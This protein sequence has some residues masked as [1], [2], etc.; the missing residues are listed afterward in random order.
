MH[1]C[2]APLRI[3]IIIPCTADV[4]D[5]C[6]SDMCMLL[7]PAQ[8]ACVHGVCVPASWHAQCL[9]HGRLCSST[10]RASACRHHSQETFATWVWRHAR[11]SG[12]AVHHSRGEGDHKWLH[13]A[14][15]LCQQDSGSQAINTS[16]TKLLPCTALSCQS[17][18]VHS[19]KQAAG[20]D[21]SSP[22]WCQMLQLSQR[23]FCG[24]S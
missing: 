13:R 17:T 11:Y 9:P 8:I 7:H 16:L 15:T 20:H 1:V 3:S 4:A 24:R 22:A 2:A 19:R 5:A 6:P 23:M 18:Q 21:H 10:P 12:T 14:C